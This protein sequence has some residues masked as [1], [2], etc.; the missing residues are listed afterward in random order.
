MLARRKAHPHTRIAEQPALP[1]KIRRLGCSTW[2]IAAASGSR[3]SGPSTASGARVSATAAASP[4]TVGTCRHTFFATPPA[5]LPADFIASDSD[6]SAH[7]QLMDTPYSRSNMTCRLKSSTREV[8]GILACCIWA[9]GCRA[10]TPK[11]S[12]TTPLWRAEPHMAAAPCIAQLADAE[13]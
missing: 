4:A 13:S 7:T 8:L 10:V 9:F 1:L 12:A 3:C 2:R 11:H 5:A 6:S